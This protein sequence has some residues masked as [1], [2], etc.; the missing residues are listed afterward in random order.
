MEAVTSLS[1]PGR[2]HVRRVVEPDPDVRASLL[3]GGFTANDVEQVLWH[4]PVVFHGR[5]LGLGVKELS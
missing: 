2:R 5:P 1:G 4:D 3:E